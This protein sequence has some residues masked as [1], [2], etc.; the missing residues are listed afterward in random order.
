[1][2]TCLFLAVGSASA[3]TV[4]KYVYSLSAIWAA[5]RANCAYTSWRASSA[6]LACWSGGSPCAAATLRAA[7]AARS[8]CRLRLLPSGNRRRIWLAAST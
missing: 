1:M 8:A 7:L 6:Y 4:Y 5:S 2:R 3:K